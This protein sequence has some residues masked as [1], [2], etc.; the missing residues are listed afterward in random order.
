MV[1]GVMNRIALCVS[2]VKGVVFLSALTLYFIIYFCCDALMQYIFITR[3]NTIWGEII[4]IIM[5]ILDENMFEYGMAFRL[6]N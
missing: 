2:A 4:I 6:R 3:K 1:I 5:I